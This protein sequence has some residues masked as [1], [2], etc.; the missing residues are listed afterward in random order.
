MLN[1]I[2]PCYNESRRLDIIYWSSIVED[3]EEIEISFTFVDDG[4]KDNTLS[5]LDELKI[6]NNVDVLALKNNIG[7]ANAIRE[8]LTSA[9]SKNAA[10][11]SFGF[12]DCDSAFSK[13]EVVNTIISFADNFQ[14][15][16]AIFPSRVNFSDSQI[17]RS[18]VRHILSR[19]IYTFMA[20]G[21]DW[22]PYDTQC[23]FKL[24]KFTPAI[25]TALDKPFKT[26]WFFDIELITRLAM[27]E[28]KRL[29]IK[30]IPLSFWQEVSDSK[31]KVKQVFKVLF[32]ILY[33]RSLLK[34]MAV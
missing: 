15:F 23:G 18:E 6:F 20:R 7:K 26:R 1:I 29:K 17:Y 12:I 32:E 3:L 14:E 24:F 25:R 19:V 16:D 11:S 4:S 30:E 5:L 28:G 9:L 22:A 13:T 2:V 34:K 21:W 10:L 8:G 27:I 33:I 31:I